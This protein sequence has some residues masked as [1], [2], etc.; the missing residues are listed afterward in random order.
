LLRT[1]SLS[2]LWPRFEHMSKTREV[3]PALAPAPALTI[4]ERASDDGIHP[5]CVEFVAHHDAMADHLERIA[6]LEREICALQAAQVD[7]IT[8]Y[9]DDRMSYAERTK[10]PFGPEQHR[11]MVAE[12]AIARHVSVITAEALMSDAYLLATQHPA[13]MAALREGR[14]GLPAARAIVRETSHL[15]PDQLEEADRLIAEEAVDVLP[16]KVRALAERRIAC[17]DPSAVHRRR[18]EAIAERHVRLTDVGAGMANLGAYVPAELGVACI[19]SLRGAAVKARAAGDKRTLGQL[20][21]DRLVSRVT[22]LDDAAVPPVHVNLVMSDS[23][24]LGLD[25]S[26]AHLTGCGPLPA[27][28]ARHLA[29]SGSSWLS[30]LLTDPIDGTVRAVDSRRRRFDGDLRE[31]ALLRDQHCQGIL[32]ASPI[33]DIDHIV[34]FS[35]G[36][37]TAL[38]NAQGLSKNCHVGRGDPRMRVHRDSATDVVTWKTPSGLVHRNL[39]PP[40]LGSGTGSPSQVRLRRLLL[41]PPPSPAECALLSYLVRQRRSGR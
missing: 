8:R 11:G 5:D 40:A 18:Q 33:V 26:P 20:M 36:G 23:T 13:T 24:L 41:H 21:T 32:C 15:E 4:L 17:L 35:R 38:A 27:S 29:T 1:P 10:E 9:I 28:V 25:D 2:A 6:G 37:P 34:E 31:L 19:E 16:G 12:V 39:P 3:A 30:R 22:G 14:L 7:E